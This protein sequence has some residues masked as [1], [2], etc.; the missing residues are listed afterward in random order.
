MTAVCIA[1]KVEPFGDQSLAIID[2]LHQYMPF[3]AEYHE[4]LRNLDSLFYS[5]NGGLGHNFLSLWAYYLSSPL[6][7]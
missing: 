2:G 4:K 7:L 5:W 1:C 6:N 3:F